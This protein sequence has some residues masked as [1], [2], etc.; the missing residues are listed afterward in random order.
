MKKI[1]YLLPIIIIASCGQPEQAESDKLND[2][3]NK[4]QYADSISRAA[5]KNERRRVELT[6]QMNDLLPQI[7]EINSRIK[8]ITTEIEVQKDKL[9]N[10]KLPKFLRAQSERETEIRNQLLKIEELKSEY[11]SELT[12]FKKLL[13]NINNLR[14]KLN[15][16][17]VNNEG[18]D[19]MLENF[20]RQKNDNAIADT[21]A[22]S[23]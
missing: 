10:I 6:S 7:I 4:K 21:I 3:I 22:N 9:E 16:P 20:E 1:L 11:N 2:E 17:Q 5:V 12:N 8:Y 23:R 18:L 19:T 13:Q 14:Q 15:L